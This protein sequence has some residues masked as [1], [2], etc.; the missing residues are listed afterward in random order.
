M[1][2][3]NS[4]SISASIETQTQI[5]SIP[6][7]PVWETRANP[8]PY[9]QWLQDVHPVY[10]DAKIGKW[11]VT[12]Y[13]DVSRLLRDTRLSSQ[14]PG[15]VPVSTG[16]L[17]PEIATSLGS[18][19]EFLSHMMVLND[20]EAHTR[21]RQTVSPAF[22]PVAVSRLK[23]QIVELTDQL[24]EQAWYKSKST[25]GFDVKESL[26]SPLP[27]AV[28]AGLMGVAI[29]DRGR[30][31]FKE[32]SDNLIGLLELDDRATRQDKALA[33]GR[34]IE[35]LRVYQRGRLQ[36][37]RLQNPSTQSL[38]LADSLPLPTAACPHLNPNPGSGSSSS[39]VLKPKG[40]TVALSEDEVTANSLLLL[41]A[42][43]ETTT[44]LISSGLATLLQ[45]P[46]QL[47]RLRAQKG[48]ELLYGPA[49]EELLRY[50]S[51][52]QWVGRVAKEEVAV[53][54]QMVAGPGAGPSAAGEHK[55]QIIKPGD[56]VLLMLG[57]ANRDP[58]YFANPNQLDI[59]RFAANATGGGLRHLAFGYGPHFCL[60]AFL[61][62]LEAE[63]ALERLF[64]WFPRL[65][66]DPAGLPLQWQSG[67]A[68]RAL[69]ALPVLV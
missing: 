64:K 32:W 41:A 5:K 58:R 20:G 6:V 57:A 19:Y 4:N 35:Q 56:K 40:S 66:L 31:K 30:F 55:P 37:L 62:R 16:T 11:L 60:G 26:A 15:T 36:A 22:T 34:N 48:K 59:N 68:V 38:L 65:R 39:S 12:R 44:N 51:P 46:E 52:V 17:M 63:V 67:Q 13:A 1:D 49:V 21:L 3:F 24:L 43:Y 7:A 69:K 33:L 42:G 10:W 25:G 27:L 18:T 23:Q 28:I 54:V 9:Y 8:Y 53:K 45:H 29:K 50:E 61:S 14:R 47:A 2:D